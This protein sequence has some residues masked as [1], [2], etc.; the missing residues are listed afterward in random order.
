MA[1]SENWVLPTDLVVAHTQN[2]GVLQMRVKQ[3]L[4]VLGVDATPARQKKPVD[5]VESAGSRIRALARGLCSAH[6]T[7]QTDLQ[8]KRQ[9]QL[10]LIIKQCR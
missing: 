10:R 9:E 2:P 7:P 8:I 5:D 3:L 1:G 4:Q 6:N